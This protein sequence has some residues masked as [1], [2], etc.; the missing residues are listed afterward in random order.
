MRRGPLCPRFFRSRPLKNLQPYDPKTLPIRRHPPLASSSATLLFEVMAT[1]RKV[2]RPASL[3]C[4]TG[5]KLG[6]FRQSEGQRNNS[7]ATANWVRSAKSEPRLENR[8]PRPKLGSFLHKQVRGATEITAGTPQIG[9]VSQ[10]ALRKLRNPQLRRCPR[11][12]AGIDECV[13]C[14]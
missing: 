3:P 4:Q 14:L 11:R 12:H 8:N 7:S 13:L 5:P 10:I 6:S 1:L 9:F 2:S